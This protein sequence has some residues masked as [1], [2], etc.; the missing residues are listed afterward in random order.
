MN[1]DVS[2]TT[3]VPFLQIFQNMAVRNNFK[4][5]RWNIIPYHKIEDPEGSFLSE[6]QINLHLLFLH[7]VTFSDFLCYIKKKN[8]LQVGLKVSEYNNSL[9]TILHNLQSKKPYRDNTFTFIPGRSLHTTAGI[10]L[11]F[12]RKKENRKKRQLYFATTTLLDIK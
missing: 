10:F 11:M 7:I 2:A 9:D 4:E 8:S 12:C 5:K 6:I 1:C 3:I